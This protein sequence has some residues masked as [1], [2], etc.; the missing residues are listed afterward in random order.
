M[1][2]LMCFQQEQGKGMPHIPM[3][4]RT[5][6][7]MAQPELADVL[8]D[9]DFMLFFVMVTEVDMVGFS[10]VARVATKRIARPKVVGEMVSEDNRRFMFTQTDADEYWF[11]CCP[12]CPEFSFLFQSCA[13]ISHVVF[14]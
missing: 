13:F 3:H 10:T 2:R 11:N 7:H 12:S 8:L 9:T 1:E 6:Q 4:M 14:F 5:R